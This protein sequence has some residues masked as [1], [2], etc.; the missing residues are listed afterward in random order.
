MSKA[1]LEIREIMV[2]TKRRI[3]LLEIDLDLLFAKIQHYVVD[4][5]Y[6]LSNEITHLINGQTS[7]SKS[8]VV[9]LLLQDIN[10]ALMNIELPEDE[11]DNQ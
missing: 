9:R 4:K 6:I 11:K 8:N 5:P 7:F 1:K 3:L 10:Q 2:P